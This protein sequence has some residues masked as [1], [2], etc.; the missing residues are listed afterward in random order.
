MWNQPLDPMNPRHRAALFAVA[1]AIPVVM[2]LITGWAF[3][4]LA[5]WQLGV[6]R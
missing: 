4:A 2:E 3:P 1:L 6:G 5:A